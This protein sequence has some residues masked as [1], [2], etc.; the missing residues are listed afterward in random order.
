MENILI[1]IFKN[2]LSFWKK[3]VCFVNVE[4]DPNKLTYVETER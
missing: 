2:E 4:T 1:S 3:Y